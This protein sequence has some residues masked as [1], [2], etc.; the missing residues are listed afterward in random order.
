MVIY[1]ARPSIKAVNRMIPYTNPKDMDTAPTMMHNVSIQSLLSLLCVY[2]DLQPFG[3]TQVAL[4]MVPSIS[5]T[6]TKSGYFTA[7]HRYGDTP[8]GFR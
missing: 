7:G 5:F 1:H 2:T 6:S 8:I 3:I 4:E